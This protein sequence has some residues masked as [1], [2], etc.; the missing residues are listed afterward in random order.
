[1]HDRIIGAAMAGLISIAPA[2]AQSG[3]TGTNTF[4]PGTWGAYYQALSPNGHMLGQ[5]T[6]G[7]AFSLDFRAVSENAQGIQR[8]YSVQLYVA[9]DNGKIRLLEKTADQNSLQ[10]TTW[11][12]NFDNAG[13]K[14]KRR[15]YRDSKYS[16]MSVAADGTIFGKYGKY[17]SEGGYTWVEIRYKLGTLV[18]DHYELIN[19]GKGG[20]LYR[21]VLTPAPKTYAAVHNGVLAEY[22]RRKAARKSGPGL[23]ETLARGTT[24]VAAATSPNYNPYGGAGST[25]SVENPLDENSEQNRRFRSNLSEIARQGAQANAPSQAPGTPPAQRNRVTPSSQPAAGIPLP[26][27]QTPQTRYFA[28]MGIRR[29]RRADGS[30]AIASI[31]YGVVTSTRDPYAVLQRFKQQTGSSAGIDSENGSGNC[32][33][34]ETRAEAEAGVARVVNRD[35]N[36]PFAQITGV[37]FAY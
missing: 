27:A 3:E 7:K 25:S 18:Y 24:E 28:C 22:E 8:R 2:F 15:D 29:E 33:P 31:S 26:S 13:R 5:L 35:R 12:V 34:Y 20:F 16:Q 4:G 21:D 1:M 32:S 11:Y 30:S 17:N 36:A 14:I 37:D 10:L 9:N 23:L 19:G 6:P